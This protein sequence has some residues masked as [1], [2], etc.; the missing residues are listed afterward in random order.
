MRYFEDLP[1]NEVQVTESYTMQ[2]QEMIDFATQWD[3]QPF[4]T[5]EEEAANWPLGLTASSVHTIAVSVKLAQAMSATKKQAAFIAG[6]GW[7]N[8]RMPHPVR[9][10]DEIHVKA[11]MS[12][13]RDSSSRPDCGIVT[14][15]FEVYNQDKVL[16]LSYGIASLVMKRP[17]SAVL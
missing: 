5:S 9:P 11:W 17:V 3:P 14:S 13:K 12:E 2:K 16:V 7:D 15:R 6:L 10:N 4:H 1:L 8:V